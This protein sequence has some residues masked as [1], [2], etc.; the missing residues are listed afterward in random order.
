[1]ATTTTTTTIARST[2]QRSNNLK[3]FWRYGRES[4]N[5]GRISVESNDCSDESN[6]TDTNNLKNVVRAEA[7]EVLYDEN[8]RKSTDGVFG[9]REVKMYAENMRALAKNA[10]V[11]SERYKNE[12]NEFFFHK[13]GVKFRIIEPNRGDRL[14]CDLDVLN[15]LFVSVN[16]SRRPD[17]KLY[18]ALKESCFC[19]FAEV[20][21]EY[22]TIELD[23]NNNSVE[24]TIV[25]SRKEVIGFARMTTDRAFVATIWDLVVS[26]PYQSKGIGTTLVEK[27]IERVKI[28][29]PGIVVNL[30]AVD[31]AIKLYQK[32]GF[33]AENEFGIIA[34]N[35]SP[36]AAAIKRYQSVDFRLEYKK[37][38]DI[39]K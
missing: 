25:E 39:T 5:R 24:K 19:A 7:G 29:S 20:D 37:D 12:R 27:L 11:S 31:D 38:E 2:K 33:S 14:E 26:P 6:S 16:F 32:I 30:F 1:M 9:M 18:L 8:E 23:V 22:K 36:D 35:Y 3:R 17:D 15:D 34:M 4:V 13:C 28:D 10:R 21:V